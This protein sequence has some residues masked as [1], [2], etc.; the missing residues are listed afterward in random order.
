M[1]ARGKQHERIKLL[2]NSGEEKEFEVIH[3]RVTLRDA[4]VK[5]V[6]SM[7]RREGRRQRYSVRELMDAPWMVTQSEVLNKTDFRSMEELAREA[8]RKSKPVSDQPVNR[9]VR[10]TEYGR[11]HSTRNY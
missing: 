9:R 4:I 6:A 7:G 8:W 3:G 2:L 1:L 5:Y 10:V 11:I